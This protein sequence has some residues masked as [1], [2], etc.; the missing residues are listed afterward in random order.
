MAR[1]PSLNRDQL[2]PEDQKYF[3]EIADSRG[4]I[5]G[6]Y[7][8]LLHSPDLAARVASTGAYVRFDFDMPNDLKEVVII[9]AASHIKSQY[10]FAAH[11]RL[12][13]EAGVSEDTIKII[14]QGRAPQGLSGDEEILVRYTLEL[15]QDRK[16][17]DGTF[18]AVK[19]K[20]GTRGVVDL[21]ALIGHY[22]LVAQILAAF[23]VELA[24]GMTAELPD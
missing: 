10:E 1:L 8:V 13:R 11:A 3:D 7:G 6:P 12:A 19:N 4:S 5:R 9:T 20:W 18:N 14:A 2:K 23:D 17:S 21:T 22:L 15:L 16:I 24:P